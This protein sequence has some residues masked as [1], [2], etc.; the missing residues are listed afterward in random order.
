MNR[1]LRLL[2]IAATTCAVAVL[3]IG[4]LK[5]ATPEEHL[6]AAARQDWLQATGDLGNTRYSSL[7]Q[8]N[9]ETVKNLGAAWVSDKFDDAGTSRVTPVVKDGLMFLTAGAKVYALDGKTGKTVWK[10]EV[11]GASPETPRAGG[12]AGIFLT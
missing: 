3:T 1:T 9:T 2:G 12:G 10:Y 4:I 5:S 7:S 11:A 8:I 6:P